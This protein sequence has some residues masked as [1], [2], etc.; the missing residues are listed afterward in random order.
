M[1]RTG[2]DFPGPRPREESG[3]QAGPL[4]G[5][6]SSSGHRDRLSEQLNLLHDGI[7]DT[8]VLVERQDT[9]LPPKTDTKA[10]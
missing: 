5:M 2:I 7:G 6:M 8:F 3:Q 10:Q 1:Q 4:A 9:Y